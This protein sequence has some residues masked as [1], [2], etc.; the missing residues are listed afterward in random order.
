MHRIIAGSKRDE[1]NSLRGVKM[2][3][4]DR[5]LFNGTFCGTLIEGFYP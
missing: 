4:F 3:V 2:P 5:K 1:S